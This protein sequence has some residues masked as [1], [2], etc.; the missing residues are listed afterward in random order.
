MVPIGS[1]IKQ[2]QRGA[3]IEF[4]HSL[5]RL[6]MEPFLPRPFA[7]SV[8]GAFMNGPPY[9]AII[10]NTKLNFWH[11]RVLYTILNFAQ[12]SFLGQHFCSIP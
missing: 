9:A 12:A 2:L 4:V 5:R 11:M 8:H 1:P 10:L 7:L 6:E 3:A